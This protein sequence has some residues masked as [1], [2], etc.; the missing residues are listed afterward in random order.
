MPASVF[1]AIEAIGAKP[2]VAERDFKW[3]VRPQG[4]WDY[5]GP[6]LMF[7]DL[8]PSSL[9]GA[10]QYRNAATAIAAIEAL[11]LSPP[12][13]GGGPGWGPSHIATALESVQ[14]QGRFQIVPGAVEWI[15]DVAHNEPAARVL[16]MQLAARPCQGRTFAIVS[17][18]GDKDIAAIGQALAPEIDRWIICTL[19]DPRGLTASE[20][21]AKL[22]LPGVACTLADSVRAGCEIARSLA[23]PGDRIVACGSFLVAGAALQWLRL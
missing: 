11:P 10:I 16:A 21:A 22:G 3:S 7:E 5:Y 19:P 18:L 13:H 8:P 17:I 6:R 4:H 23:K 9:P 15:L 1:A 20:L 14:L 2:V 12:F